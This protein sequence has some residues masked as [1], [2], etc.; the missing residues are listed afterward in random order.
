[1]QTY[2]PPQDN[3]YSAAGDVQFNTG[4]TFNI[5]TTYD[6]YAVALHEFGHALGLYH[7]TSGNVMYGAYQNAKTSLASDDI[8]GVRA[9]YSGG[10]AR[11][12]DGYGGTNTSFSTAAVLTS[13]IGS[14][15]LTALVNNLTMNTAGGAEY[16]TFA[17]PTKTTSKLTVAVQSKGLSLF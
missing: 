6:L 1:A 15:S 14:T 10:S 5:G 7:S 11:S 3:N 9:I 8:A 2:M 17:A 16:Y 12:I 13:V 4:Q